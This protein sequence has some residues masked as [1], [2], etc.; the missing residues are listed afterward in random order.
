MRGLERWASD[1]LGMGLG[2]RREG[3]SRGYESA[4]R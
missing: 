1:T 4:R 3:P 2:C